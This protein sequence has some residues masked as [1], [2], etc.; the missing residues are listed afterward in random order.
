VLIFYHGGGANM[1]GYGGLAHTLRQ[2]AP[3]AVLTPDIRGHG[4]SS[5]PRGFAPTPDLVWSDIDAVIAWVVAT[6]PRTPVF[7]GGHSSG[8][9][10]VINWAAHRVAPAS[11]VA[12]LVLLTPFVGA[13]L[14]KPVDK[15]TE[16]PFATARAWIFLA[17]L[18]SGKRLMARAEAVRFGYPEDRA[19]AGNLVRAYS[20][21]MSMAVTPRDARAALRQIDT[22]MLIIAAENDEIMDT[23]RLRDASP[24]AN[25]ATV[26]GTHLSCF[27]A[28]AA[29]IAQ[30]LT[31]NATV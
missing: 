27:L 16:P 18:L 12:G 20:A 26:P 24:L 23:E 29:P 3:I 31:S 6:F 22:P 7:V 13:K 28:A 21:G 25:F 15:T 17:Y 19:E 30:F 4:R 14:Q 1:V 11:P 2:T 5:G 10:L 8:G 9:G